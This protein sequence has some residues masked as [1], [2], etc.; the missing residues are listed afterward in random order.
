M[1]SCDDYREKSRACCGA[2]DNM[3]ARL[4][5]ETLNIPH[6]F[7]D[8]RE[9][10]KN[11]VLRP[12]WEEYKNGRTPNPCILCNYYL[13]FGALMDFAEKLGACGII[14]GHYS[15]IKR[16]SKGKA[17]L[18]RNLDNSKDQT[19]FLSAL[20][21]KQLDF[22]YMPLGC[23]TKSEVRETAKK[24]GLP[25]AD[26]IE[27]QDACFGYK[28]E[29]F[30]KTLKRIFNGKSISGYLVDENGKKLKKHNGIENFTIGQRKGLGIALGKPGYVND[31]NRET[32]KVTVSTNTE[33]LFKNSFAADNMNWLEF[34]KQ[35]SIYEIQ[36]RYRQ[37]PVRGVVT[38]INSS[39]ASFELLKPVRA[40]TPGQAVA[41]YCHNRLIGG[42]GIKA[43]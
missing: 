8:V 40:V 7:F 31:I 41:V 16:D 36:T 19:Y 28:D 34:I 43:D 29:T 15:I 38:E 22:S 24:I 32:G 10:F 2:E 14:T 21:Q 25:N 39:T 18:Y 5:A 35:D 33:E 30:Q 13:K 37:E 20:T 27:S 26:K 6:Y 17:Y 12:S 3:Q 1:R 9:L 4:A 11:K 23:M 42:G